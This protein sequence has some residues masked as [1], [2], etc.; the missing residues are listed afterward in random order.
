MAAQRR[1]QHVASDRTRTRRPRR[2]PAAGSRKRNPERTREKILEAALA[3]FG[4][5]GY[6]GARTARIAA[7]AGVNEQLISY[8][9]E[10]K[11]GLYQALANRWRSVSAELAGPEVPLAEVVGNFLQAS[12][13]HRSWSRLLAWEGLTGSS[14]GDGADPEDHA[15]FT[16]MVDDL[17]RRQ[18]AGEVAEDLDPAHLMFII[19]VATAGPIM[20]PQIARQLTGQEP[21]SAE[22]VRA[23]RAQLDRVLRHLRT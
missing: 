15:F 23:Y 6:A 14:T 11:A 21:D 17:R 16:A 3:E 12:V 8:Y 9:F 19:F 7:R 18:E 10:G 4:E 1:D 20:L 2:A 22:F 5:H 13:D